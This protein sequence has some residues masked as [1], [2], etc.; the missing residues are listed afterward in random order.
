MA[1][2][3]GCG[4]QNVRDQSATLSASEAA[5][6][7]VMVEPGPPPPDMASPSDAIILERLRLRAAARREQ[8][9][10][11]RLDAGTNRGYIDIWGTHSLRDAFS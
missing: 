7:A 2:L 9:A 11:L 10:R 3:S 8:A 6:N 4:P 5:F 1:L